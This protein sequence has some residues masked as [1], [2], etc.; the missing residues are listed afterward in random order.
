MAEMSDAQL[1]SIIDKER[2]QGIGAS[3]H[4]AS[5][6]QDAMA[7]YL[8]EPE[9]EL[10]PPEIEGRSQVVSKDLMETVE[11]V[12]PSLMRMF[13]GAD[14][15]VRFEPNDQGDEQACKDATEYCAYLLHR[16]NPGFTVLHDAIKSSLIVREGVVKVHC[17]RSFVESEESYTDL[18]DMDLQVLAA[19]KTVEIVEIDMIQDVMQPEMQQSG[20][21][22]QMASYNVKIKRKDRQ[23]KYIVEGVPPEEVVFSKDSRDIEKL[24]FVAHT[25]ERTKSDLLSLGYNRDDVEACYTE[26]DTEHYQDAQSRSDYD[27][28]NMDNDD[29]A[30]LSQRLITLVEAYMKVDFDGDGIAEYRRV[31]KAG[32][33]VF[34]NDV[35]D[36]HP[37]ALF[38]PVLMPYKLVGLSFYDLIEDLQRIK[39]AITRQ[40]LDSMYLANN[41]RTVVVD[42]QVNLDDLLVARPGGIVR[43]KSLGAVEPFP[44][45]DISGS[46]QAS[47]T[48]FNQVRDSRSGVKEYTQGLVGNELSQ[49]QIGSQGVAILADAA[50]QRIELIARVLAETGIKR[51]YRLLLKLITQYQDRQAQMKV[52]GHWMQ[53]D[54]RSWKHEYDMTVSV[55]IGTASKER[56]QQSAM[57]ILNIQKEAAPMGFVQPQNAYNALDELCETMGYRD[58]SRFFTMPQPQ[59]GPKPPSPEQQMA[60]I[61][62]QKIQGELHL[63]QQKNQ[64]DSQLEHDKQLWQAQEQQAQK[65]LETERNAQQAQNQMAL[66]QFKTEK[67]A[68]LERFKAQLQQQTA[69]EIARIN[70]EAKIAAARVSGVKDDSAVN[71]DMLYQESHE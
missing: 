1:C 62:Q 68:E 24:R 49:S 14:D 56:K 43:A 61:Q 67:Q 21:S 25:V 63:A 17:D 57:Q 6:R 52:N 45:T 19:D 7:Y 9:G 51:I 42:G 33:V 4:I 48:F 64:M 44:V 69:I 37:F 71:A 50:A 36:S 10:A 11:W 32:K 16:K 8:G 12:M 66:E 23:D 29:P 22:P 58:V 53:I 34:E 2:A 13:C 41:P 15:V 26:T 20:A 55:G 35:V 38:S 3:D 18:S 39:T 59:T 5:D 54:P 60:Q 27:G 46:A 65:Q 31:V 28:V 40:M 30:D 47:I 70:A